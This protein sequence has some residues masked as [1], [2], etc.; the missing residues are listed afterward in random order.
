MKLSCFAVLNYHTGLQLCTKFEKRT[1]VHSMV[2]LDV[3]KHIIMTQN[4]DCHQVHISGHFSAIFTNT[5]YRICIYMHVA[6][7]DQR[8]E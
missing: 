3:K 8:Y 1:L 7:C 4:T 5:A 6:F 2:S